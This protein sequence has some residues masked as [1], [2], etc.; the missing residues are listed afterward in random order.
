[1]NLD[2]NDIV[3]ILGL[4]LL[5]QNVINNLTSDDIRKC[6][7]NTIKLYHPDNFKISENLSTDLTKIINEAYTQALTVID[8][9]RK[10]TSEVNH[11]NYFTSYNYPNIFKPIIS[12]MLKKNSDLLSL[13]KA[14]RAID[15]G[16][17]MIYFVNLLSEIFGD[18]FRDLFLTTLQNSNDPLFLD[19]GVKLLEQH[20]TYLENFKIE[21]SQFMIDTENN[22]KNNSL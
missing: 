18:Y 5:D 17:I 6:Y 22:E 19:R 2:K 3:I 8:E 12:E 21:V 7:I 10:T 16:C 15:T 20:L 13:L 11:K 14:L 9:L 4:D 1:M